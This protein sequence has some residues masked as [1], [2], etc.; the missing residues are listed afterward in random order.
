MVHAGASIWQTPGGVVAEIERINDDITIFSAEITAAVRARGLDAIDLATVPLS[1][2]QQITIAL[3]KLGLPN[4]SVDWKGL[5]QAAIDAARAATQPHLDPLVNFYLATWVPFVM[6]WKTF[7]EANRHW[8]DQFWW[9]HAPEA[10]QFLAQLVEIR[11]SAKMLGMPVLSPTPSSWG[12][13]L[14]DPSRDPTK[15]AL[16]TL[17][18]LMSILKWAVI[19]ALGIAGVFLVGKSVES[20]RG[21]R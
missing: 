20:F 4:Q 19:G 3:D 9:N 12:K 15:P 8:G 5:G 16:D 14:L 10:E 7:F 18:T 11:Q 2:H 1:E 17:E 6:R 21:R 13:S